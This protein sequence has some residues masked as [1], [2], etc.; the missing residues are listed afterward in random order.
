MIIH[1][2]G[3]SSEI[4]GQKYRLLWN[5]Q[6]ILNWPMLLSL[7]RTMDQAPASA[8]ASAR[9]ERCSGESY[10][11]EKAE[12]LWKIKI[13]PQHRRS[14][15]G[16]QVRLANSLIK[17]AWAWVDGR[18]VIP[19]LW[20]MR[21]KLFL[22]PQVKALCLK[23]DGLFFQN[24]NKTAPGRGCLVLELHQNDIQAS[25]QTNKQKLFY[26]IFQGFLLCVFFP[27]ERNAA[28]FVF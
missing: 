25:K 9:G 13:K 14:V 19:V 4:S 16:G 24:F 2:T 1:V 22:V 5:L 17:P 11:C 6:M 3:L 23:T 15:N 12:E 27:Q 21:A 28:T 20:G 10:I 18:L 7:L 8:I 26:V